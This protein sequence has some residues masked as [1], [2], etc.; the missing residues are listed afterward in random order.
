MELR[1]ADNLID[2]RSVFLCYTCTLQEKDAPFLLRGRAG[3]V[4]NCLNEE[5]KQVR[6]I[7]ELFCQLP[8]PGHIWSFF[9]WGYSLLTAC[10]VVDQ[11]QRLRFPVI[12]RC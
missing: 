4:G 11:I 8:L 6:R 5:F 2:L 9:G 10:Y 1:G 3:E 12:L 7:A